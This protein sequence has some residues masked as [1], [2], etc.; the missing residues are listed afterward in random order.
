LKTDNVLRGHRLLDGNRRGRPLRLARPRAADVREGVVNVA[1]NHGQI[2]GRDR[3]IR[4][5]GGDDVRRQRKQLAL[6][7]LIGHRS[8]DLLKFAFAYIKT[9]AAGINIIE[10]KKNKHK[11]WKIPSSIE[12]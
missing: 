3:I 2:G 9:P 6:L 5:V 11:K 4:H 12:V 1:D 7:R 8:I 10:E